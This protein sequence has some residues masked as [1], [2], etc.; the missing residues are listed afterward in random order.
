MDHAEVRERLESA[1]LS[2]GKLNSLESDTSSE[3]KELREHLASCAACSSE[4]LAL[5]ETGAFLAAAAPDDLTP[6]A[7]A[8][9]ALLQAIRETGVARPLS[10]AQS[11]RR[12]VAT[13]DRGRWR[14]RY[15]GGARPLWLAFAAAAA[16]VLVAGAIA[17]NAQREA[18]ERET[19]ELAAI[20]AATDRVLREPDRQTV[21]LRDR[22]GN[23]AGTVV[24]SRGSHELV[25]VSD[26]LAI[27]AQ[28]E[29]YDCYVERSG[30][31]RNIGWMHFSSGLAYWAGRVES[32][33][34]PGGP[35]A[36][37][38]VTRG[39]EDVLKGEL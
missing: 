34:D 6:P 24:Y 27:P 36:N 30:A 28:G 35:P 17:F 26:A 31:R 16:V 22:A 7:G 13:A 32:L 12:G 14:A 33:P 23:P 15:P 20:T 3:G 5:R 39:A 19:R 4:L 2:P 10:R 11:Q 21:V 18:G 1:L 37:F 29:Q 38:V 9:A 25:V 8:R